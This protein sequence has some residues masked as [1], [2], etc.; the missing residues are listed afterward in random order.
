VE[1]FG[2]RAVCAVLMAAGGA[3]LTRP[4]SARWVRTAW[5]ALWLAGL[6]HALALNLQETNLLGSNLAHYYL[7]SKYAFRYAE[8]YRLIQAA[9]AKPPIGIRDLDRP[10]R[11]LRADPRAQRAYYID[12][13]RSTGVSFDPLWPLDSL[14]ARA[15]QSGAL[16]GE[17]ERV[18]RQ[19]LPPQRIAD[20]RRDVLRAVSV[21]RPRPLTDDY[22][23]NGSPFYALVRHLD[24]T[25]GRPFGPATAWLNLAWQIVASVLLVWIAGAALGLDTNGRLAVGG[26]LFA[27]HDFVT[28][29]LPG[30]VFGELWLPVALAA[31][32]VRR[33]RAGA[34][35]VAVAWAGLVKLFPFV[36][37]LPAIVRLLPVGRNRDRGAGAGVAATWSLRF[38][39]A[40]ALAV[41][42][43]GGLAWLGGR[44]WGD[45]LH[46]ITSE[47]QSASSMVNSV[48]RSAAL[49]TLG[50]HDSPVNAVLA[51]AALVFL[52]A[53]FVG[54]R[55]EDFLAALPRRSLVLLAAM[56]WVVH[57]W[58]NYYFVAAYLLLPFYARE[59]RVGVAAA[60]FAMAAAFLLP[61]FNDP[62]L[63]A[64][65]AMHLLK[66]LPYLLV[67]A[68]MV[69]L[70]LRQ[71][72]PGKS[73]R[74]V[75][76]LAVAVLVAV[77][78]GETWRVRTMDQLD[79]VG[80][81]CLGSGN[82]GDA[83][84][85]YRRLRQLSPRNGRAHMNEG[86]ALATLGRMREARR[87]FE[88][89]A[90]LAPD[91]AAAQDNFGRAL[92]MEGR[93]EEAARQLE[94]ARALTPYDPEILVVLARIRFQQGRGPEALALLARARELEPE[95]RELADLSRSMGGP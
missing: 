82:A 58:L 6:V 34:A 13:L 72:S 88:R 92:L 81:A 18:L 20:F 64:R 16:A 95:S 55:D 61:D 4:S 69:L 14:A 47:F 38:L 2:V 46:K 60:V 83:L 51:V 62:L 12:L 66:L 91:N 33:R 75:A 77:T 9:Q 5:I 53:M 35:G 36:L 56:G 19:G 30:L 70:E 32:A 17:S 89:A 42:V 94:K 76:V 63:L 39:V 90:A 67:P 21:R 50:L 41:P 28:F 26:L 52:A 49:L 22:G 79:Q 43:L 80:R 11:L 65:P 45:F 27:S 29:T 54:G 24:P 78:A 1:T 15:R 93:V 71:A 25:L 10:A 40:C 87:A 3:L 68:W 8:F 84:D 7:G 48:S 85:C 23:F 59:H 44:S 37:A 86:I 73:P 74:W 57:G 31:L